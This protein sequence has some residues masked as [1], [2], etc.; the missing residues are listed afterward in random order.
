MRRTSLRWITTTSTSIQSE[1][2]TY[3]SQEQEKKP[4]DLDEALAQCIY[5]ETVATDLMKVMA[6]AQCSGDSTTQAGCEQFLHELRA[7]SSTKLDSC[8]L[9]MVKHADEFLEHDQVRRGC[10]GSNATALLPNPP[11]LR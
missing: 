11:L 4:D 3:I 9:Y 1:I 2:N 8:S 5:T 6:G 10:D 7:T